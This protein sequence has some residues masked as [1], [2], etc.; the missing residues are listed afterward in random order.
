MIE[1]VRK[2][3]NDLRAILKPFIAELPDDSNGI[4]I[5]PRPDFI[6]FP[7]MSDKL[8]IKATWEMT[9]TEKKNIFVCPKCSKKHELLTA[10]VQSKESGKKYF[11]V[12]YQNPDCDNKDILLFE[13]NF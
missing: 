2:R 8:Y 6:T 9:P 3:G 10:L 1:D 7:Q 11:V 5:S 4:I 12:Q 13:C